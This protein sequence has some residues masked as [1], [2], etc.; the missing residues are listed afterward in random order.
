MSQA[1]T[2]E[3]ADMHAN[4]TVHVTVMLSAIRAWLQ[5]Q[6]GGRYIDATL[7]GGG[8]T[9]A[10]L[11]ASAP[12]GRVLAID[13]DP[14]ARARVA[15]RMADAI[16]S[17]RLTIVAGNFRNLAELVRDFAPVQGIVMDLGLSSDQLADRERGFSFSSDAPLDMRFDPTSGETAAEFLAS[18][19]EEEI[20]RVL[21]E[22]GEERRSRAIARSIVMQRDRE[23]ITRADQLAGLVAR[24]ISGRPGGIHPAT[25]TFQALRIAVNG[26]LDALREALPQALDSL[27]PDGRLAVIS[28]H[29]LED[30]I[31][32]QWMRMEERGCICPPNSPVCTCG[33]QPRL[34]VL[35][36]HPQVAD[37]AEVAVNPRARSAKLRVVARL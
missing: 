17:G 15:T 3:S 8:H 26:E 1:I 19:S 32:K 21:Y 5:P 29:S 23:P 13:A 25:R 6:D 16:A 12:G 27:S 33:R 20:A 37:E 18:A 35:T 9:A 14:A 31:V 2:S 10:L 36:K 24:I 28:F 11:D 30:R 22:Y 34:K 4:T 7:G